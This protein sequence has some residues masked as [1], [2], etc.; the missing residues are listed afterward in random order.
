MEG[1]DYVFPGFADTTF[2][3][4]TGFAGHASG[5][6]TI[7]KLCQLRS[8]NTWPAMRSLKGEA[9]WRRRESNPRPETFRLGFYMHVPR[10]EFAR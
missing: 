6:C 8:L 9:W 1:P 5:S 2:F 10:F 3:A 4:L 7:L